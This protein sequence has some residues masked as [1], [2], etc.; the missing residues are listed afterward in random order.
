MAGNRAVRTLAVWCPDW[1]VIAAGGSIDE[2][3]AGAK[4][5]GAFLGTGTERKEKSV[6]IFVP[7]DMGRVRRVCKNE[8]DSDGI[9]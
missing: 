1:P 4:V 9:S 2:P 5:A 6:A 3:G 7:E 8:R